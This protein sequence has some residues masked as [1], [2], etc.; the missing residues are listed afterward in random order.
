[1][2]NFLIRFFSW[3]ESSDWHE[4]FRYM[5]CVINVPAHYGVQ[6]TYDEYIYRES[7]F[8]MPLFTKFLEINCTSKFK[9]R[10]S[11]N[12]N[13]HDCGFNQQILL[14]VS[15]LLFEGIFVEEFKKILTAVPFR[16]P[17]YLFKLSNLIIF[18]KNNW[19]W[20]TSTLTNVPNFCSKLEFMWWTCS[21]LKTENL[22][23]H[24]PNVMIY[25]MTP[26]LFNFQIIFLFQYLSFET[27]HSESAN[28]RLEIKFR[29]H[30]HNPRI[31]SEL[32]Q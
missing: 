19:Q 1:M 29:Y 22:F 21:E 9:K 3:I 6:V 15:L 10:F 32:Q 20:E 12:L 13:F 26:N 24:F 28:W 17:L 2:H 18:L 4:V 5:W 14:K 11:Q 23:Y 31:S 30:M 16:I 7:R 27:K 25:L 8:K